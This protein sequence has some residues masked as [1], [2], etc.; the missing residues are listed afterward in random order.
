MSKYIKIKR[1]GSSPSGKTGHYVVYSRS[2]IDHEQYNIAGYIKWSGAWR[3]YVF[4]SADGSFYD[5]SCLKLVSEFMVNK[6]N[7]QLGRL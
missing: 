2:T 6:T 3:Q 4:Y 1:I 5:A 7:E